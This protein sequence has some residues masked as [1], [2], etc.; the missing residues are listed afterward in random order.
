MNIQDLDT[1][2]AG[3]VLRYRWN[4]PNPLEMRLYRVASVYPSSHE[5]GAHLALV[6]LH[7]LND[8]HYLSDATATCLSERDNT[9]TLFL[10]ELALSFRAATAQL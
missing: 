10:P 4:D 6:Q 7:R 1:L 3:D 8:N 5:L 2:Q 9:L